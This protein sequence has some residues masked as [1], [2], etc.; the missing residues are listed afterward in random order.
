MKVVLITIIVISLIVTAIVVV[1]TK[2]PTAKQ[3]K[4]WDE[5]SYH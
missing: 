2:F 1:L 3:K 5:N 4:K